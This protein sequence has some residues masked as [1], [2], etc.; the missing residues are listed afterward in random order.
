M[1]KINSCMS[2]LRNKTYRL[3][4]LSLLTGA[5]LSCEK[6][7]NLVDD[8]VSSFDTEFSEMSFTIQATDRTGFHIFAEETFTDSYSLVLAQS[9]FTDGQIEDITIKEAII[10]VAEGQKYD[11]F[12]MLEFIELTAYTDALGDTTVAWLDPIP[13]DVSSITLEHDGT[14]V[15]PYLKE[16]VFVLSAQGILKKRITEDTELMARVKFRVKGRF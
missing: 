13:A 1:N 2:R 15:L 10:S 11:N 6:V 16:Q 14:S 4:V 3:I 9:G 8:P 12:N 7:E 5:L